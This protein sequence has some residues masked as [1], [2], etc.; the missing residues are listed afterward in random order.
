[1]HVFIFL[2]LHVGFT[3]IYVVHLSAFQNYLK[4]WIFLLFQLKT[5][6]FITMPYTQSA[7]KC[8][9]LTIETLEQG[10]EYVQS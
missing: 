1:M 10:V 6:S 7:I 8:P 5:A 9:K 4:F 2:N 3:R